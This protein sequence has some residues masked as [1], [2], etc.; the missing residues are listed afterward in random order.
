[1][2]M[3]SILGIGGVYL[4]GSS[5]QY[6]EAERL[7]RPPRMRTPVLSLPEL[8]LLFSLQYLGTVLLRPRDLQADYCISNTIIQ[9]PFPRTWLS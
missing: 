1:M 6:T 8:R 4:A 7:L 2:L 9:G 3:H 5:G